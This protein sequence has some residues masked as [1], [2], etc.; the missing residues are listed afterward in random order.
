MADLVTQEALQLAGIPIDTLRPGDR[1]TADQVLHTGLKLDPE[2]L[3]E[4][5]ARYERGELKDDPRTFLATKL[6]KLIERMRLEMGNPVVCRTSQGGII[7]LTDAE[8][9]KYLDS[10]ANAGLR[11]HRS[12]TQQLFTSVNAANLTEHQKR[13]LESKQTKHAFILAAHQ[14]ARTQSLRMQ[15]RGLKLPKFGEPVDN[16]QK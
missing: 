12:K 5:I 7:V 8:A 11:K 15:R 6:V 16:D 2:G 4:R 10:Q 14:G 13:E 9:M 3:A 1:F